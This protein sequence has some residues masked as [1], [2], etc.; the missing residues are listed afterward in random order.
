MSFETFLG[1][2]GIDPADSVP[3]QDTSVDTGATEGGYNANEWPGTVDTSATEATDGAPV[4]EGDQGATAA[5]F[6]LANAQV[7]PE[8]QPLQKQLLGDYTRKT[9]ELSQLRQELEQS[10]L[11]QTVITV[12]QLAQTDPAGLVSYLEQQLEA[13][14]GYAGQQGYQAPQAQGQSQAD[15]DPELLTDTERYFYDRNQEMRAQMAQMQQRLQGYEPTIQQAQI[16]KGTAQVQAAFN[17]VETQVLGRTLTPTER[18][19]LGHLAVKHGVR[20]QEQLETV[21]KAWDYNNARG[22]GR[23]EASQAVEAK[24]QMSGPRR[25]VTPGV[26]GTGKPAGGGKL[27]IAQLV[28]LA[29]AGKL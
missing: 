11:V 9:Q 22:R 12:Q 2:Q 21:A 6:D 17:H 5:G 1:D 20:T 27:S 29:A 7:P 10:P 8:L 4:G 16:E 15:L 28:D 18:T 14:R 13:A 23:S 24:Q 19:E 25:S 26:G 3:D